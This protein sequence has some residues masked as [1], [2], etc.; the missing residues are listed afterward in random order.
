M[1]AGVISFVELGAIILAWW[2]VWNFA[3]KGFTALHA[4]N[5][6]ASGLAAVL[7]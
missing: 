5:P 7:M 1:L 3:I 2:I 4:S 6:A